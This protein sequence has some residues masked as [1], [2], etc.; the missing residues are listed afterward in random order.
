[1]LNAFPVLSVSPSDKLTR[2]RTT[3]ANTY[4]TFSSDWKL[5]FLENEDFRGSNWKEFGI[6]ERNQRRVSSM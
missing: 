2:N 5:R 4:G 6:A 1:M 3:A